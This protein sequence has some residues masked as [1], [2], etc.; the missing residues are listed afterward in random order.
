MTTHQKN[1]KKFKKYGYLL[2]KNVF[3]AEEI[4]ELKREISACAGK[5]SNH[6]GI[7]AAIIDRP[8]DLEDFPIGVAQG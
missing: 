3:S 2:I 8:I 1:I 4:K 7:G 5:N 6:E